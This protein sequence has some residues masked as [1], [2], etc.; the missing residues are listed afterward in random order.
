M[1]E[2]LQSGILKKWAI[3]LYITTHLV[4]VLPAEMPAETLELHAE[5]QDLCAISELLINC[6]NVVKTYWDALG[7]ET[8]FLRLRAMLPSLDNFSFA[9]HNIH[10]L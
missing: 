7:K 2:L 5:P 4:T 3:H 1:E 8:T 9:R 6:Y 10:R